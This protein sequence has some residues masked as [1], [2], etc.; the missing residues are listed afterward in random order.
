MKVNIMETAKAIDKAYKD[1]KIELK[2][3][4]EMTTVLINLNSYLI[5][6]YNIESEQELLR[7]SRRNPAFLVPKNKPSKLVER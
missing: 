6:V 2:T 3:Y 4:D 1:G 5:N 7:S